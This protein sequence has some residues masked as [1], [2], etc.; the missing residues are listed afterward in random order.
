MDRQSRRGRTANR[1]RTT[2]QKGSGANA[3]RRNRIITRRNR[4]LGPIRNRLQRAQ[5]NQNR[6]RRVRSNRRFRRFNNFNG[7]RNFQR[8]IIYIGGLPNYITNRGLFRL[9][10]PEGRIIEY[11][12]VR[13]RAGYSR[14]F[15]FIEFVRPR[16]AWR[17]IQK[18][19]NT[20]LGPNRITVRYRR[21]NF[22]R[23]RF[24]NNN[25]NRNNGRFNQPGRGFG[26]RGGRGG[27]GSFR[28]RFGQR[29]RY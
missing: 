25:F 11:S 4:R 10:R 7:N 12:V 18:W 19:N 24:G 13:N 16:D 22:N 17:S 20:T 23:R 26:F 5:N 21:R 29:G 6:N 9:F 3:R 2:A 27:R 15:G 1:P 14:G 28:G 8:R